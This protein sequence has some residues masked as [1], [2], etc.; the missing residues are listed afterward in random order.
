MRISVECNRLTPDTISGEGIC[1]TTVYSSKD[2][3]QIDK[4]EEEIRKTIGDFTIMET[5]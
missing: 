2:K 5:E 1:I 4:L 3:E